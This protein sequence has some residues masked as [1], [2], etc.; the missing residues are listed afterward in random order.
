MVRKR[1]HYCPF[2]GGCF[3]ALKMRPLDFQTVRGSR[4]LEEGGCS[5]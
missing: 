2:K 4:G 3:R 5:L 1:V